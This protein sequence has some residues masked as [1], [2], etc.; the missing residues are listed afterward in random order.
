MIVVPDTLPARKTVLPPL[1]KIIMKFV[2][3]SVNTAPKYGE[4]IFAVPTLTG[5]P[6][7]PVDVLT[8]TTLLSEPPVVPYSTTYKSADSWAMPP[9]SALEEIPVIWARTVGDAVIVEP[10]TPCAVGDDG[11]I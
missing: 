3:D 10:H 6:T 7:T 5:V 11:T 4:P 2:D 8:A 9:I 1:M